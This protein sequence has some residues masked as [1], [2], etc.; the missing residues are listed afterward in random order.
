[1]TSVSLIDLKRRTVIA[2]QDLR[3]GKIDAAASGVP[4]GEYP[5]AILWRDETHAYVSAPRDRQIVVLD[6]SGEAIR[7]AKRIAT[8]GEPT[9]ML[10]DARAARLYATEDNADRLAMVDTGSDTLLGRTAPG[11]AGIAERRDAGQGRE[12]QRPGAHPGA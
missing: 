3:P 8:I 10:Y 9:A 1:M 2:E 4:G 11:H 7:V 6:M 12:P 5:F